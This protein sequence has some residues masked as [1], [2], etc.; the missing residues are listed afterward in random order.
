MAIK[1]EQSKQKAAQ[2]PAIVRPYIDVEGVPTSD[3]L[4]CDEVQS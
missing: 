4:P 3:W 2:K 1:S